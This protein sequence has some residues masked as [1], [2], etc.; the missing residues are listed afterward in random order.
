MV[1]LKVLVPDARRRG[2]WTPRG[3]SAGWR[4]VGGGLWER[5]RAAG[6]RPDLHAREAGPRDAGAPPFPFVHEADFRAG[7]LERRQALAPGRCAVTARRA[8]TSLPCPMAL[9]DSLPDI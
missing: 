2:S 5:L 9:L 6:R 7:L 8:L 3:Q 4:G 1:F